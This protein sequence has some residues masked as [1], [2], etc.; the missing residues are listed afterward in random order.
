MP[1]KPCTMD[2]SKGYGTGVADALG[3]WGFSSQVA[4]PG[5]ELNRMVCL[6]K[7]MDDL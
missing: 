4:N 1:C 3:N 2:Y 6:F 5:N 7:K